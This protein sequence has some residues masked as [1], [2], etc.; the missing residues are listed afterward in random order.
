[1]NKENLQRMADYIRKIPQE[2]FSMDDYRKGQRVLPECDSV[3]CVVGHCTILDADN[4]MRFIDSAG[5]I[6]FE[7][8]AKWF[9]NIN[10]ACFS[11]CFSYK[12]VNVDNTPTG[13]AA[14][15]E[16]LIYNGL[17]ENWIEQTRGEAQICYQ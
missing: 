9:A 11:W 3:G 15:I 16:W 14:R 6:D 2:M 7:R 17:P 8:W 5:E 12:W 10:S 13:A 1:M 4:I